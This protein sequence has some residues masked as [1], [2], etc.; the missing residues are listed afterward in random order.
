[1]DSGSKG[2]AACGA[3]S[4]RRR[5]CSAC[6]VAAL[7][8]WSAARV[9]T[10]G[11]ATSVHAEVMPWSLRGRSSHSDRGNVVRWVATTTMDGW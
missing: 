8:W 3:V 4:A 11:T 6:K 7:T 2:W 1:M 5:T 9:G 10:H